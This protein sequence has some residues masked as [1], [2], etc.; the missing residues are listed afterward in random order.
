MTR[1]SPTGVSHPVFTRRSAL[2]AGSIGLLGLGLSELSALR[3]VASPQLVT[4][5]KSVLFVLLTGGLSHQVAGETTC[6]R[7][8]CCRSRA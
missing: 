1:S 7:P 3:S 6:R 4:P 8:S 5:A 2:Q